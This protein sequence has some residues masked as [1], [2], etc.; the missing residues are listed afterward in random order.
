[1]RKFFV[2]SGGWGNALYVVSH[3]FNVQ[4]DYDELRYS[5]PILRAERL[6]SVVVIATFRATRA[7]RSEGTKPH[8]NFASG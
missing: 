6:S 1:M 5:A 2:A 4:I 3:R 8:S 7:E